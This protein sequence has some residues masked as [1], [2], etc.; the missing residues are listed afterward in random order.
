MRASPELIR[1]ECSLR[2]HANGRRSLLPRYKCVSACGSTS[3][4][5][6]EN[7]WSERRDH[8]L[9]LFLYNAGARVSKALSV[10]FQNVQRDDYRAVQLLGK[11]R[12]QG[13]GRDTSYLVPPA[14]IPAAVCNLTSRGS[15]IRRWEV[16]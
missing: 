6:I 5:G 8:L 16:C 10:R 1:A 15:L 4:L 9:F 14:Q 7:S 3:F 13:R 12:K 11:G 2:L